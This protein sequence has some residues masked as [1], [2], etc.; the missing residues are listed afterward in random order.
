M[1]LPSGEGTA[2]AG[3]PATSRG[4]TG[5]AEIAVILVV[6]DTF[7]E[8]L[9]AAAARGVSAAPG[10][11]YRIGSKQRALERSASPQGRRS[12]RARMAT[13][14]PSALTLGRRRPTSHASRAYSAVY[15]GYSGILASALAAA[16]IASSSEASIVTWSP[17]ICRTPDRPPAVTNTDPSG[18]R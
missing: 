13:A 3:R 8:P 1:L 15:V 14:S 10:H 2:V 4:L 16:R 12:R 7:K 18:G 11:A 6:V 5:I 17:L 9:S